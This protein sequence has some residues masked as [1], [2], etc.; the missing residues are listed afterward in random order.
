[1]CNKLR[2]LVMILLPHSTHRLQ[3]LDVGLFLPLATVYSQEITHIIQKSGGIV[4]LTKRTFWACFKPAWI[5]AFTVENV[6]SVFKKTGI[7]PYDTTK[8]INIVTPKS[9]GPQSLI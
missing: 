6:K 1:M 8:V 3:P 7:W 5:R 9:P 4:S 2:I